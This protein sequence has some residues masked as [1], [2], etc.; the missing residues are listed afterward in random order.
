MDLRVSDFQA[1]NYCEVK[2]FDTHNERKGSIFYTLRSVVV[3]SG[4][5]LHAFGY[6]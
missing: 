2:K 5:R 6:V 3:C 4:I 1:S